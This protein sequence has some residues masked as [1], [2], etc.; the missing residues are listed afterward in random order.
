M[1]LHLALLL[2]ISIKK[3]SK[4]FTPLWCAWFLVGM[5]ILEGSLTKKFTNNV[6]STE[7]KELLAID[8]GWVFCI[9]HLFQSVFKNKI[10]Q[11]LYRFF[12]PLSTVVYSI[13][14]RE[15]RVFVF[16]VANLAYTSIVSLWNEKKKEGLTA[17]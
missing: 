3:L 13:V 5:G 15:A 9:I 12:L 4:V 2:W 10:L 8:V 1:P 7:Y 11:H 14:P 17:S 16:S 6:I